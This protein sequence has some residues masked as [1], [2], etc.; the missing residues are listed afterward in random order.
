MPLS[1]GIAGVAAALVLM[2]ISLTLMRKL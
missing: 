2:G 1:T